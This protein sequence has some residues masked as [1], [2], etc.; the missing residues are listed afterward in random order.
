MDALQD[1]AAILERFDYE[2]DGIAQG[3]VRSMPHR[4]VGWVLR[5]TAAIVVFW[6][7]SSVLVQFA[8]SLAAEHMLTRAARSAVLEATLP[9][10]TYESVRDTVERRLANRAWAK[11]TTLSVQR[12]GTPIGGMTRAAS[13]DRMDVTLSV[14]ARAVV[15][16][17]LSAIKLRTAESQIE[18]RAERAVP[19]RVWD[20]LA[21]A[22]ACSGGR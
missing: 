4:G 1:S 2:G 18:V 6:F 10:A 7:A 13:G 14:P 19:G 3:V 21:G 22:Q 11:Q 9:R 8:Y 12:N 16:P 15:P 17:W 5:W 20:G